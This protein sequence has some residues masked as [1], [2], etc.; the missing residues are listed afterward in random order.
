MRL[1][2]RCWPWP[3]PVG[4]SSGTAWR[5]R[6]VR[7]CGARRSGPPR[8][9]SPAG[10]GCRRS[11]GG[12]RSARAGLMLRAAEVEW[13]DR[14]RLLAEQILPAVPVTVLL[15]NFEDNL[16]QD[17]GSWQVRDPELAD[18]LARWARRS[19]QSRLLFTSRHPFTLP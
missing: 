12:S 19:G 16:D 3:G 11:T 10:C 4:W 13:A 9:W 15:D 6:W 1:R 17:D 8:R 14:W 2:I 18:L 5:C 7:R